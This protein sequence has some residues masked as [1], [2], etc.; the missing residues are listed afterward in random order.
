MR[1]QEEILDT[2]DR[3]NWTRGLTRRILRRATEH[4]ILEFV[5]GSTPPKRKSNG[6]R[7]A[8]YGEPRPLQKLAPPP[9]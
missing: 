5:E 9:V 3:Q 8:G 2:P 4:Q 1:A 6:V 7:R